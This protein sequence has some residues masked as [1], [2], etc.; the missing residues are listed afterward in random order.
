MDKRCGLLWCYF[1]RLLGGAGGKGARLE[2]LGGGLV[3]EMWGFTVS[4]GSEVL[5]SMNGGGVSEM[6]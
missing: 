5:W 3:V 6:R 2:D 4:E 1:A